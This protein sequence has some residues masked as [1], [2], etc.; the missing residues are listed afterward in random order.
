MMDLRDGGREDGV[1]AIKLL[2]K[3]ANRRL[4]D[5]DPLFDLLVI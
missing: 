4:C 5:T 3:D 1:R 2:D